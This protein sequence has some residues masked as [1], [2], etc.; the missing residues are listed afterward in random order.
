M[1]EGAELLR[2]ALRAGV[3]IESVY[4][5]PEGEQD[6]ATRETCDQALLDAGR[7]SSPSLRACSN[8]W[9]TR[10]RPSPS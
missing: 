1:A 3:A 8:G 9:P 7:G 4:L 5:A 10:S 2:T 6:P